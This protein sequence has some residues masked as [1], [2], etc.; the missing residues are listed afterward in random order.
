MASRR[1][2]AGAARSTPGFF[3]YLTRFFTSLPLTRTFVVL[4]PYTGFE[5]CGIQNMFRFGSLP[6]M[7][8][9][10]FGAARATA[11]Q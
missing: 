4:N 1:S 10:T 2:Y 7:K 11:T 5:N 6:M 3:T 8:S 9:V